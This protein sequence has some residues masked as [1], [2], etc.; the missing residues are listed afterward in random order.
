MQ[1]RMAVQ[2]PSAKK[3]AVLWVISGIALLLLL[4]GAIAVATIDILHLHFGYAKAA[5]RYR[6][7]GMPW[8]MADL[9]GEP[10]PSERNAAPALVKL[11]LDPGL[12]KPFE[13]PKSTGLWNQKQVALAA[14]ELDSRRKILDQ[15]KPLAGLDCRWNTDM[16]LGMDALFPE[17]AGIK[18][19]GKGLALRMELRSAQGDIKGSLEDLKLGLNVA[20]KVSKGET[21]IHQLVCIALR[22]IIYSSARR[23]ASYHAKD[24]K[25]LQAFA[26]ALAS[27]NSEPEFAKALKGEAYFGLSMLRNKPIF[28]LFRDLS[29]T[30]LME[31]DLDER[32]KPDPSKLVRDGDPRWWLSRSFAVPLLDAWAEVGEILQKEGE[33]HEAVAK[34]GNLLEKKAADAKGL[35]SMILEVLF[36]VFAQAGS[37]YS[38][39]L[40]DEAS[41]IAALRLAALKAR[42]G[43]IS[44]QDLKRLTP[45]DPYT[46]KPMGVKVT[47]KGVSVWSFGEDKQDDG[48]VVRADSDTLKV[49]AGKPLEQH[50]HD[51]TS[52]IPWQPTQTALKR[53]ASAP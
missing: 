40:A 25:T 45:L 38:K 41:T 4:L 18:S 32:P 13:F 26:D 33:G 48:G 36:P 23:A 2:E 6:D 28:Q 47:A 34:V 43:S 42:D 7:A 19:L 50:R 20:E 30:S 16:D 31:E 11:A 8:T 52:Q 15:Y 35:G 12:A 14:S 10:I 49:N 22:S 51:L 29:D 24:P 27:V 44:P 21:L 37:A 46:G 9:R 53:A 1:M 5:K 3:R 17:L 39:T